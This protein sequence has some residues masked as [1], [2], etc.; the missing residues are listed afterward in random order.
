MLL[1]LDF[2]NNR[3][4]NIKEND[5]VQDFI[6]ELSDYLEGLNNKLF[7]KKDNGLKQEDC[8][9]QVVDIGTDGAYLQNVSNNQISY[10]IDISKDVLKEIGNDT[11]LRYKRGEYI[12][13]EELTQK[14]LDNLIGIKEYQEIHE[15]FIKKSNILK[16]NPNTKYKIEVKEKDY[17]ILS[18]GTDEKDIIKVPKELIPYWA[19]SG[20]GL[21]YE[22]GKFNREL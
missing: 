13:E 5:V 9:Y 7:N 10:E 1:Q 3:L 4:N 11:V 15:N 20:E 14:F 21:Y 2:F 6:K 19:K 22:K 17:S 18:Y 8:I 12:I 16:N